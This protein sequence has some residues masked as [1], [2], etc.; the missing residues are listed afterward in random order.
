M[1][2]AKR[3]MDLV[4]AAVALILLFPLLAAI[5]LLVWLTS[6]GPVLFRQARLGLE[7][8][9]FQLLKFRTMVHPA[10]DLRNA[11]GSTYSGR[12]DPRVTP[13]GRLLR[14]TSLDELPQLWNVLRG[15]M[16]LVGPRPDQVDQ[17][18]YYSRADLEKLRVRPGITGLAQISGRNAIPWEVRRRLDCA[19]A[20]NWNLWL[21]LKILAK[22]VPYVILRKGIHHDPL[23]AQPVAN[24][25]AK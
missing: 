24:S 12:D 4:F 17:L 6:P 11:D 22:T 1:R 23:P 16:S 10:P 7:G 5:A 19:Y 18:Q 21:D 9:P 25:S 2:A 8:R 15:E 3:L 13:L 14:A 20:S